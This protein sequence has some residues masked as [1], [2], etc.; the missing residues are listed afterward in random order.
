MRFVDNSTSLKAD[1]LGAKGINDV[2]GAGGATFAAV[3][4]TDIFNL[5]PPE[6]QPSPSNIFQHHR[7]ILCKGIQR[8]ACLNLALGVKTP[9]R[10]LNVHGR[11]GWSMISRIAFSES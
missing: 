10:S 5:S 7:L 4:F 8:V 6:V 11:Y 1:R 3:N 2:T 9:C